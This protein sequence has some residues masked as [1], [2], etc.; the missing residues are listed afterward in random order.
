MKAKK[1]PTTVLTVTISS[2][3]A[4]TQDVGFGLGLGQ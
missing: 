3:H 2:T 1:Y 4:F